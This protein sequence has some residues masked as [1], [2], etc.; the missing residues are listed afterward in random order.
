MLHTFRLRIRL[1]VDQDSELFS[2][3][4]PSRF[5]FQ[6]SNYDNVT[7][8]ITI[9]QLIKMYFLIVMSS[10]RVVEV[11]VV[12]SFSQKFGEKF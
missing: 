2:T 8:V 10:T 12:V 1:A 3:I 6:V 9:F 7:L 11:V 5:G 4:F